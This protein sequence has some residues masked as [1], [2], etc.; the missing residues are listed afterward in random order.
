[1]SKEY[2]AIREKMT[3]KESTEAVIKE[4]A[5]KFSN[6]FGGTDASYYKWEREEGWKV[7]GREYKIPAAFDY[8]LTNIYN[9]EK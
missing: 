8:W 9:P 7:F 6:W 5:I 2:K 4:V 1:M 3:S